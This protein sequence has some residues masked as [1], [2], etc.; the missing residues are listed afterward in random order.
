MH[1][2]S[3]T[4]PTV[5]YVFFRKRI[6]FDHSLT[7]SPQKTLN[8]QPFPSSHRPKIQSKNHHSLQRIHGPFEPLFPSPLSLSLNNAFLTRR[9]PNTYL[10]LGNCRN[11]LVYSAPFSTYVLRVRDLRISVQRDAGEITE[12]SGFYCVLEPCFV[13]YGTGNAA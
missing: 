10:L 13:V 4:P 8:Y 9:Q 6:V 12:K 5:P 3:Q 1:S 2:L 7:N 11:R